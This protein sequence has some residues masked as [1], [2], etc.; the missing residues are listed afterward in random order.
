MEP[1]LEHSIP[2]LTTMKPPLRSS[3]SLGRA[4]K[5]LS[6]SLLKSRVSSWQARLDEAIDCASSASANSLSCLRK[7]DSSSAPGGGGSFANAAAGANASA[8][9]VRVSN[10]LMGCWLL[11]LGITLRH[12]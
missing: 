5:W 11:G 8:T 10:G 4:S 3:S 1:E 12:F 2:S 7:A 9:A 6:I